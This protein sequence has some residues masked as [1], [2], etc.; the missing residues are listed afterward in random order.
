MRWRREWADL[1]AWSMSAL[2]LRARQV[3]GYNTTD[4][5]KRG[6]CMCVC[7]CRGPCDLSFT[8]VMATVGHAHAMH[9]L[10]PDPCPSGLPAYFVSCP[11]SSRKA[12]PAQWTD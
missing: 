9:F 6:V 5:G 3:Q 10:T 11:C 1:A 2:G 12:S 4:Q 7:V 8:E